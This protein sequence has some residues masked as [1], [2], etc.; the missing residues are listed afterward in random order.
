VDAIAQEQVW[1]DGGADNDPPGDCPLPRAEAE[2][3]TEA[4]QQTLSPPCRRQ[5]EEYPE[6]TLHV[7]SQE[8]LRTLTLAHEM[9]EIILTVDYSLDPANIAWIYTTSRALGFVRRVQ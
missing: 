8:Y 6:G 3:D 1:F 4:Y 9:G 5:Y 2:V 7:S